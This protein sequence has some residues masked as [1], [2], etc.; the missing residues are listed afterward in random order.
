MVANTLKTA[1]ESLGKPVRRLH[2]SGNAKT[3]FTFQ[4]V[5]SQPS[6]Y[7]D[8]ESTTTLHTFRV[9]LYSKDDFTDLLS[10]T[11]EV[12]KQAGFTISSVDPGIYENDTEF[13]HVP[14]TINVMEE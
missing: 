11:L 2:Y 4:T 1:L 14:I 12:L 5:I 3:Y 13:Y 10:S 8:D 6:G 7:A 9:D